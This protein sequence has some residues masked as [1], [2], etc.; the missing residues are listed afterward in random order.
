[1]WRNA[2]VLLKSFSSL[3][4]KFSTTQSSNS[5]VCVIGACGS[6]G[7]ALS[8][9]LKRDD[10]VTVLSLYDVK[11][12]IG[13]ALDMSHID[14]NSEVFGYEKIEMLPKAL[15]CADVVV[16]VAGQP[17]KKGMSENDLLKQNASLIIEIMPHIAEICP[18]ALIAIVTS[19][20]N[21]I[22]PLAAE[23]LKKKDAFD[24]NRL[25]GVTT[26]NVVRARTFISDELQVDASIVKVPVIG[27]NSPCTILPVLTHTKPK[28]KIEDKDDAIPLIRKL[29]A[30]EDNVAMVKGDQ[31]ATLIM[32]H[33]VAKFTHALLM[34]LAGMGDPVECAYVE[35]TVT[36]CS[37]FATPLKLGKQGIEKN[38]GIP[39]L[40]K[41]EVELLHDLIPELKESIK[42]GIELAKK[43]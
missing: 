15:Y 7:Q 37:F 9:L 18:K 25:F 20:T 5:R 41:F 43:K 35:S 2:R 23:V 17:R 14:T 3:S 39:T 26:H 10:R 29:R 21:A 34:G 8:L 13:M 31:G 27:G 30:A 4:R 38:L 40:A 16:I 19:P 42:K 22:V 36:D 24:P 11:K 28:F 33:S 1:M 32:A 12:A 6:V